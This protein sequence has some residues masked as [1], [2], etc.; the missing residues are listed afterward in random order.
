MHF[1]GHLNDLILKLISLAQCFWT[2]R[3]NIILAFTR[4]IIFLLEQQIFKH[5]RVRRLKNAYFDKSMRNN[6]ET[7]LLSPQR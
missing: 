4:Q 7:H 2:L 6:R 5:H 3:N 1:H